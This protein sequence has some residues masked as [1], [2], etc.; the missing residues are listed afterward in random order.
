MIPERAG[1]GSF[2]LKNSSGDS[3]QENIRKRMR[4]VNFFSED[5]NLN[6]NFNF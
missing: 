1:L 3:F 6:S 2:Q 5:Y 4:S